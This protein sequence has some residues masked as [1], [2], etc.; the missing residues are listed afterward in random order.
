MSAKPTMQT[1]L[2]TAADEAAVRKAI[3]STSRP[4]KAGA[5]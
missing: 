2:T 5:L 4:L 3:S 1:P